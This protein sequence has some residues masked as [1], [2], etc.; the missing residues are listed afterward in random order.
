MHGSVVW[1]LHGC[2]MT[3]AYKWL[4]LVVESHDEID[5]PYIYTVMLYSCLETGCRIS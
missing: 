2:R 4:K 1:K 3:L 5:D